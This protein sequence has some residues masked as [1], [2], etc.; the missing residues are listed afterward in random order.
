[1]SSFRTEAPRCFFPAQ[2]GSAARDNEKT[3]RCQ[4]RLTRARPMLLPPPTSAFA[5]CASSELG[6]FLVVA[7]CRF[8][9]HRGSRSR[10]ALRV[11]LRIRR[12]CAGGAAN[13][14]ILLN[15]RRHAWKEECS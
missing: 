8:H 1:R 13:V 3:L 11:S 12:D 15:P 9:P 14:R 6:T 7:D 4:R 2:L 5:R 10:H